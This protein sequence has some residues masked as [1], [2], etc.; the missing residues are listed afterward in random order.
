[1]NSEEKRKVFDKNLIDITIKEYMKKNAKLCNRIMNAE[2]TKKQALAEAIIF[3]SNTIK[4]SRL[5]EKELIDGWKLY[6]IGSELVLRLERCYR[7]PLT[8]F[9]NRLFY[10]VDKE[11]V[12]IPLY[13]YFKLRMSENYFEIKIIEGDMYTNLEEFKEF[14]T[15]F[16]IKIDE[17]QHK[18]QRE[19]LA[20]KI[21]FA[22]WLKREQRERGNK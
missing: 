14:I 22:Y 18:Y 11:K 19:F 6:N 10:G 16:P 8:D 13:R 7:N 1:M 15:V 4:D 9:M 20:V 12:V 5:L 3:A 21:Q 17:E 2:K